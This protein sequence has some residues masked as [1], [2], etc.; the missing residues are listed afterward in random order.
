MHGKARRDSP[1]LVP[2]ANR[3]FVIVYTQS[4]DNGC[5]LSSPVADVDIQVFV[6]Y[7]NALKLLCG[8]ANNCFLICS[9]LFVLLTEISCQF[10]ICCSCVMTG[11]TLLVC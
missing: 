2:L 8:Y 7:V 1:V 5:Q 3:S 9:V 4:S 10:L 11:W 6:C